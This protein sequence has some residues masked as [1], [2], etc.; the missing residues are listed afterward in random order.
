MLGR[1]LQLPP[2]EQV[3]LSLACAAL[4]LLAADYWVVKPVFA[5]LSRMD[6]RIEE[7]EKGISDNLEILRYEE[8]IEIQ[9]EQVKNLIGISS[10]GQEAID[11]KGTIDD[12]APKSG[13]SI[14]SRKLLPDDPDNYIV[15]Y[16]LQ[17]G[18]FES[19]MAALINFLYKVQSA[20]GLLRVQRLIVNSQLE[21]NSIK[22]KL[23]ISK[24]MTLADGQE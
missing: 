16:S 3:G 8:S 2:R 12:M 18:G 13:I 15:T 4:L 20:P 22:G 21:N 5:E 7:K 19:E 9:Y 17:I 23:T 10:S 1:L 11:F 14:K 6:V 24:A